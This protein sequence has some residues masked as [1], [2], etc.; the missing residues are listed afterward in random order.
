MGR[1]EGKISIR[2]CG[3]F[4]FLWII[5]RISIRFWDVVLNAQFQEA[6]K[7]YNLFLILEL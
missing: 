3:D 2:R 1:V 6:R 5:E 7:S 4:E